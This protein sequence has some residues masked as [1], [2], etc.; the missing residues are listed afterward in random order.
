M[1]VTWRVTEQAGVRRFILE[2]KAAGEEQFREIFQTPPNPTGTYE[3]VDES[4]ARSGL[5][6]LVKYQL[7]VEGAEGR[8]LLKQIDANYTTT[9]VRRTWGSIKAMFQ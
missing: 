5:D 8:L 1:R 6:G 7:L 2:R 4:L 3:F 9:A